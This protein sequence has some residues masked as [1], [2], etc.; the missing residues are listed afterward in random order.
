[1]EEKIFN[2]LREHELKSNSV[3]SSVESALAT[4]FASPKADRTKTDDENKVEETII[5]DNS[6]NIVDD[7]TPKSSLD[8]AEVSKLAQVTKPKFSSLLLSLGEESF[9]KKKEEEERARKKKGNHI[10]KPIEEAYSR[11]EHFSASK[12]LIKLSEIKRPVR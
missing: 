3:E 10:P 6:A 11:S 1:M 4:L 5:S 12:W 2:A 7:D 8:E 9:E